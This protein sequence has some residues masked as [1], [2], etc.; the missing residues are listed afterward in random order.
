IAF[1]SDEGGEYRLHL[2]P[3]EGKGNHRVIPLGGAGFYFGLDWSPDGKRIAYSDNSQTIY[4]LD[5]ASGKSSRVG[6]NAIYTPAEGI[7]YAWSPDSRWLAYTVLDHPLVRTLY[8]YDADGGKSTAVTDGLS[9]VALPVFD[10]SGKYLY[11][12]ASTDAGPALDWFSQSTD[13]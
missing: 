12:V 8:L 4:V 6:A 5:V 1:V 10:R 11:V 13:G 3:Q 2:A 9:E 7:G